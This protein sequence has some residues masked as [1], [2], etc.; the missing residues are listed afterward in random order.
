MDKKNIVFKR[1]YTPL[2]KQQIIVSIIQISLL[3]NLNQIL[4]YDMS[5]DQVLKFSWFGRKIF[6]I[7]LPHQETVWQK[8][9][10]NKSLKINLKIHF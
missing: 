3:L 4:L 8:I 10:K 9:L 6:Q 7:I 1:R 5:I 2:I